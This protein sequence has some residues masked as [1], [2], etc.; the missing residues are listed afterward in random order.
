MPELIPMP[1]LAPVL[2]EVAV[3]FELDLL[4]VDV[5]LGVEETEPQDPKDDWQ[6]LP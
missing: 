2:R 6:P 5:P 4:A 3:G 1:T